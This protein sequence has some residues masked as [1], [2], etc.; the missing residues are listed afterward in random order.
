MPNLTNSQEPEPVFLPLGAK[1]GTARKKIQGAGAA[2]EKNQEPEP[3]EK[4]SGAGA[5]AE[6]KIAGSPALQ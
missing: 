3:L 4:K 1:A 6:K 2:W 5:G